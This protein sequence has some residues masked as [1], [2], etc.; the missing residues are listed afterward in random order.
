[1]KTLSYH[2]RTSIFNG[3]RSNVKEHIRT[4]L[5]SQITWDIDNIMWVH[6]GFDGSV[7]NNI[8]REID[9]KVDGASI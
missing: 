9:I 4:S 7:I 6:F 5:H 3:I 2:I 8:Y 1:M